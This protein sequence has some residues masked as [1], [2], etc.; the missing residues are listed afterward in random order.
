[1]RSGSQIDIAEI[2]RHGA[3]AADAVHA[4]AA[5]VCLGL[6][7]AHQARQI[8]EY[9]GTRLLMDA[10]D[11]AAWR[12]LCQRDGDFFQ[13]PWLAPRPAKNARS[14]AETLGLLGQSL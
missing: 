4:D 13:V 7:E 1:G 5:A 10:P 2:D 3:E 8:V 6:G 14:E 12:L 9:A 11:P